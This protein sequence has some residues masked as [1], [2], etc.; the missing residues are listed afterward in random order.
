MSE[1]IV[2]TIKRQM[3]PENLWSMICGSAWESW[4]W[5][6]G[7]VYEGGD[8]DKPCDLWVLVDNPDYVGDSPLAADRCVSALITLPDL[9]RAL[10]ELAD[11]RA[12]MEA[13]IDDD[14]D[15]IYG[16]AVMQQAI[17]GDIV[18]G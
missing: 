9:I 10:E 4:P 2:V 14:F 8:W 1:N 17:F 15:A 16:D 5:W 13:L 12:V 7:W 11:H 6:Y 18:F 3:P